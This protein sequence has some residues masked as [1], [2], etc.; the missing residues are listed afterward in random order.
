[1][2]ATA[3]LF[4]SQERKKAFHLIDLRGGHWR[5]VNMPVWTFGE[6]IANRF[7]LVGRVVIHHEMHVESCWYCSAPIECSTLNV[8]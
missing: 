7:G 3:E 1:M 6:K 8:S 2:H 5:Q 4:V